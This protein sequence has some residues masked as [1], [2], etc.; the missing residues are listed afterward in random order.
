[1][2]ER[3]DALGDGDAIGINT[4]FCVTFVPQQHPSFAVASLEDMLHDPLSWDPTAE[5]P[6]VQ[7][8]WVYL[9][10]DDEP[11]P[12]LPSPQRAL[13]ARLEYAALLDYDPARIVLQPSYPAIRD[14]FD[15]GVLADTVLIVSQ[16]VASDAEHILY[17]LDMRP[18]LCGLTWGVARFGRVLTR[19]ILERF[20]AICPPGRRPD[21]QGGQVE[22]AGFPRCLRV[23]PGNVL[24][25]SF[26]PADVPDDSDSSD[27]SA[28]TDADVPDGPD[29]MD[30][31]PRR[32]GHNQQHAHVGE[33]MPDAGHGTDPAPTERS[34]SPQNRTPERRCRGTSLY[35]WVEVEMWIWGFILVALAVGPLRLTPFLTWL[36]L[37][38]RC[39]LPHQPTCHGKL[40]GA[41]LFLACLV[42]GAAAPLGPCRKTH[43]DARG[44]TDFRRLQS[45]FRQPVAILPGSRLHGDYSREGRS[46]SGKRQRRPLP[47]PLLAQCRLLARRLALR[48]V[49]PSL[50]GALQRVR[51]NHPVSTSRSYARSWRNR[52]AEPTALLSRLPRG[53]LLFAD[54]F[55]R[56][57]VEQWRD[58]EPPDAQRQGV[59]TLVL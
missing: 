56:P 54:A 28:G 52:R 41:I 32:P 19:P 39:L 21:I 16:E 5:L 58:T 35:S 59:T 15:R 10:T 47:T 11:F 6:G 2:H 18:V 50:K 44:E 14:H 25:V 17:V 26:V 22:P 46:D 7:D 8:R 37:C 24:T 48:I 13:P 55:P 33:A 49:S 53:A 31:L 36:A 43:L 27:S 40:L 30:D 9:L 29:D 3:V 45:R 57:A 51:W 38:S 1:M 34:R 42:P 23:E 12:A 20:R 4:G